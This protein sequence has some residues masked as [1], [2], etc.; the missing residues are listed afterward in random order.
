M[1]IFTGSPIPTETTTLGP[2]PGRPARGTQASPGD[3]R[4]HG[5]G[6]Q[7]D[8]DHAD[9]SRRPGRA[10]DMTRPCVGIRPTDTSRSAGDGEDGAAAEVD[11]EHARQVQQPRLQQLGAI[12]RRRLR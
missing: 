6:E 8:G 4:Q 9:E 1:A 2:S 12:G 11:G 10:G 7:S 3:V 5:G